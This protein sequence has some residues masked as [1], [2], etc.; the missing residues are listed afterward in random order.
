M[1]DEDERP[2]KRDRDELARVSWTPAYPHRSVVRT[3]AGSDSQGPD[4]NHL[5]LN[6]PRIVQIIGEIDPISY[7][8]RE[9]ETK[10]SG[11]FSWQLSV[12]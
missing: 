2:K 3:P 11:V 9:C 6:G 4:Q 1:C 7:D 12:N 10:G 8:F 5:F